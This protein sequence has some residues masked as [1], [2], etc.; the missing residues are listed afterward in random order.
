LIK[1]PIAEILVRFIDAIV[2]HIKVNIKNKLALEEK[3]LKIGIKRIVLVLIWKYTEFRLSVYKLLRI[4]T[5]IDTL[6]KEGKLLKGIWR[7]R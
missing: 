5:V 6:S 3:T 2:N 1:G 4:D 7:K